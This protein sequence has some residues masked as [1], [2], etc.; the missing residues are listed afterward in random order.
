MAIYYTTQDT[1]S[2]TGGAN[3]SGE[4]ATFEITPIDPD[5]DTHSGYNLQAANFIMGGA[6]ES[7]GSGVAFTQTDT[8][9]FYYWE[10]VAD[11][12]WNVDTGISKVRF[13]NI[14]LAGNSMNTIEVV[15]YF[16]STSPGSDASYHIDIDTN[17]SNPPSNSIPR[18]VCFILD[19]P[20]STLFTHV[21]YDPTNDYLNWDTIGAEYNGVTR[22]V[23]N[24][25]QLDTLNMSTY[26]P[27]TRYH[28]N[29]T[30]TN[31]SPD[32]DYALGRVAF[33]RT[34]PDGTILDG[35]PGV[36]DPVFTTYDHFFVNPATY[37]TFSG[38]S[39]SSPMGSQW[40]PMYGLYPHSET[41]SFAAAG[42]Y[43]VV[44]MTTM[45]LSVN[46]IDENWALEAEDS[47]M[48]A[49]GHGFVLTADAVD[50]FIGIQASPPPIITSVD[51]PVGFSNSSGYQNIVVRG[52]PGAQYSLNFVEMASLTGT[53]VASGSPYFS[54]AGLKKFK[55]SKPIT[56]FNIPRKGRIVHSFTLPKTD[57]T[58]RYDVYV[59]PKL[60]TTAKA[61]VPSSPGEKFIRQFGKSTITIQATADTDQFNLTSSAA[62][63]VLSRPLD[64]S[65]RTKEKNQVCM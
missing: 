45:D 43:N 12:G 63:A 2:S 7:N 8:A 15:V 4:T 31:Y 58:K 61:N 23:I 55:A 19:V 10:D 37:S 21:F 35:L 1:I 13:K 50:P 53:T 24:S 39:L 41:T 46:P 14:G 52:T 59:E 18:D 5:T 49:L 42:L 34:D 6:E 47:G 9:G 20:A 48:C 26:F 62:T 32:A 64:N 22:S 30:I 36:G 54:F 29:G 40:A 38:F 57:S 16:G 60:P 56:E 3:L 27:Y 51:T 28:F 33:V 25:P 17:P 65:G 11:N 44:Y